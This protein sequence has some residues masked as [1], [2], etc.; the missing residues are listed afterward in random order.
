MVIKWVFFLVVWAHKLY[1]KKCDLPDRSLVSVASTR[2]IQGVSCV[3][4]VSVSDTTQTHAIT[5]NFSPFLNYMVVLE[6]PCQY[7]TEVVIWIKTIFL[8]IHYG[9]LYCGCNLKRRGVRE[10]TYTL[11]RES[12]LRKWLSVWILYGKGLV[13]VHV[14]M[15]GFT[16]SLAE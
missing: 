6:C 13:F 9:E 11:L 15:F 5:F 4:H 10:I 8:I 3:W 7:V 1:A 2:R 12:E 16:V 14:R